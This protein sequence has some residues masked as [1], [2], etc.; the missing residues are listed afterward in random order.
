MDGVAVTAHEG[1]PEGI[2]DVVAWGDHTYVRKYDEGKKAAQP[3]LHQHGPSCEGH[4]CVELELGAVGTALRVSALEARCGELEAMQPREWTA[5]TIK[6][7]PE[8]YYR[9]K[10]FGR[11]VFEDNNRPLWDI[12]ESIKHAE[13]R[14]AK[15][16][17]AVVGLP[18]AYF[19]PV[20]QPSSN[21][22]KEG[23][24]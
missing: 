13:T 20:P 15:G 18:I 19:G 2:T 3:Y 12:D 5:E 22:R 23:E 24:G 4:E 11:G 6:D 7:A 16:L 9:C 1:L 10:Y 8:G 14:K 17:G 21:S